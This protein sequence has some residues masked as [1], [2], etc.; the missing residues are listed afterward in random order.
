MGLNSSGSSS[1]VQTIQFSDLSSCARRAT[2]G[3][4]ETIRLGKS[5]AYFPTYFIGGA[6]PGVSFPVRLLSI[7]GL[8]SERD[9]CDD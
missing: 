3:L 2:T 6:T 8:L 7:P 4:G 1:N 9:G 5:L